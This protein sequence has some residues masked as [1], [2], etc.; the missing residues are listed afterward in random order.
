MRRYFVITA[1][2]ALLSCSAI[3][4]TDS[5]ENLLFRMARTENTAAKCILVQT[6]GGFHLER[7]RGK[8]T[9]IFEGTLSP[10]RLAALDALLNGDRFQ[11]L[12]PEAVSSSLLPTGFEE[13]L[14][15][16]P[17]GGRWMNLRFLN[18]LGSDRNRPLLE[19]F[20]KWESKVLE[21]PHRKLRE[22][23]S[24]NNCL[25]AGPIELKPR[26]N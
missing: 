15:S 5:T 11:Q 14:I 21:S 23:S 1:L 7:S 13:T 2:V 24:R 19:Q 22:E 16:V 6:N 8:A 12:L 10:D 3:A 17:R 18:G 20:E 26:R 4:Q 9:Q 25:P